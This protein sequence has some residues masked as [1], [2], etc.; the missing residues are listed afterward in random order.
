MKVIGLTGGIGTGKS[1]A[2]EYLK[3]KGFAHIDA[4][5]IGRNMTAD[6]SPILK[7]LNDLFG[8]A[9]PFGKAGVEILEAPGVLD[10]KAMADVVFSNPES[11]DKFNEIMFAAII[12]EIKRQ[13]AFYDREGCAYALVDAPLLFESGADTLCDAVILITADLE[14]RIERVQLRD[15]LTREE[16][17]SRIRNQMED[18]EK[19]QRADYVVDNSGALRDLFDA[20]DRVFVSII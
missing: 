20:L 18:A 1:T 10:R 19:A 6:H 11:R 8:P 3:A 7:T 15:N 13:I 4:D 16:I 9:G 14:K 5:Q 2:A 17:L 12:A